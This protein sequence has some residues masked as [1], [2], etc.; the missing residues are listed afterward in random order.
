M[1]LLRLLIFNI[2]VLVLNKDNY[3]KSTHSR[4]H[5]PPSHLLLRINFETRKKKSRLCIW[6]LKTNI[7]WIATISDYNTK[8]H[9]V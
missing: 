8:C 7:D 2:F 3:I 1:F 6:S 5:I 4:E 9:K